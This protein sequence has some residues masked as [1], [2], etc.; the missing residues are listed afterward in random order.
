MPLPEIDPARYETQ[1]A[2][3]ARAFAESFA[4]FQAPPP[5]LFRSAPLHYR[6]RAEFRIWHE[7]E[8]LDYVMFDPDAPETPIALDNFPAGSVAINTLMPL[9]RE[10]LRGNAAL[11]RKLFQ[12]EFLTTLSGAALVTLL[13]HRALDETWQQAAQQ[14]RDE[15]GIQLIG[16]SRKQKIV[17]HAD[18]LEETLA[19]NGR[20]FRYRQIENSF[21]QPNGGINQQ[22]LAWAAQQTAELGGDLLELY[23]GNGNF[24]AVLAQN[25]RRVL[26]TEIAKSSVQAAQYNLAANGIDNVA[27]VRMSSDE[28]ST[29]LAGGRAFRRLRDID[30]D[31]YDFRTLL[32]DPPRAGLDATT[33]ALAARFDNILYISCNPITLRENV[34]ALQAT[35]RIAALALFDQFPY[36]H[37]LECGMLLAR[38][39]A[40][41]L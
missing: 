25:F 11:R 20:E 28:I 32:V 10:R 23:C 41:H 39:A 30:L 36:T 9:L 22:M 15:L 26:A 1:L 19:V 3:K 21:T 17:L 33:L 4:Q 5:A 24:T 14:L 37:H 27:L 34:A 13:Y 2:D 31:D 35:H 40:P 29:A 7:G 38:R 18:H 6:L 16:R 8:R 12:V